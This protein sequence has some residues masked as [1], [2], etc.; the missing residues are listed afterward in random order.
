MDVVDGSSL[1]Q[2][3]RDNSFPFFLLPGGL[4]KSLLTQLLAAD[5]TPGAGCS[6]KIDNPVCAIEDMVNII[7]LE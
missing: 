6:A 1:L 3:D 5:L 2:V 7:D 4:E